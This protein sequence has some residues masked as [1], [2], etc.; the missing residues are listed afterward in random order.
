[1][2]ASAGADPSTQGPCLGDG[3]WVSKSPV[4]RSSWRA[5]PLTPELPVLPV[6]EKGWTETSHRLAN[7][8][9]SPSPSQARLTTAA[10][11]GCNLPRLY[12]EGPRPCHRRALYNRA[13]LRAP[14]R[15][16]QQESR[17][18]PLCVA[19]DT[20]YPREDH[21][22]GSSTAD[23]VPPPPRDHLVWSIFNTIYMNFCCLGFV[24]LAFSVKVQ[25]PSGVG[26]VGLPVGMGAGMFGVTREPSP[27]R[28]QGMNIP[29]SHRAAEMEAL[30]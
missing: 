15:L 29:R 1:M 3:H 13:A 26:T 21:K 7:P 5:Q 9:V 17:G 24:A 23:P 12:I 11:E 6:V 27:H 18:V 2:R 10:L 14:A 20:S 30:S 8:L 28:C 16:V 4:A 19:M 22:R 25:A